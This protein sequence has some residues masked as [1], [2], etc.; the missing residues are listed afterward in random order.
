MSN[1]GLPKG[2]LVESGANRLHI[3]G[4]TRK[5]GWQ[6]L[7]VVPA[8]YVDHVG[9]LRDLSAFADG[10]FDMVYASHVMEH[11]GYQKDLKSAVASIGRILRKGGRFFISVPDLEVLCRL[12]AHP[13]AD[14]ELR[15]AVMRM[16]FGGQLDPHDFHYVGLWDDYLAHLL[17]SSGFEDVFR[18]Q[19][20]PFFEDTSRTKVA[21]TL[22]SLNMVAV[23]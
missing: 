20:F 4:T 19:E 23:K 3:G 7:N 22:I 11:L 9:D 15:F 12:F 8:D 18:V 21:G 17:F 13:Q 14:R 2:L 5:K 16:M 1:D 6:V 10:S